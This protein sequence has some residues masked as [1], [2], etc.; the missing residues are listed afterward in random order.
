MTAKLLA[1]L[2]C[3][4]LMRLYAQPPQRF[5]IIITELLPDPAPPIALPNNEFIEL[6]N[7]TTHAINLRGWKLSDGIATA[8]I[9]ANI[10]LQPDSFVIICANAAVPLYTALGNTI[11]ITN[12][13]SLN[14]DADVIT[15]YAP[16]GNAIHTVAYTDL[17]YDNAIKAGGG[18][19]LEMI[20]TRNP[21]TGA[22]NWKAATDDRGGTPGRENSIRADNPDEM[23]P[24]LVGA[25]TID[26]L[27]IV[28]VFDESLDSVSGAIA[29]HYSF[30]HAMGSPVSATP[31]A[32]LFNEVV[33]K[34]PT[35]INKNEVYQLT[36][37]Q[38]ADCSGNTIGMMNNAKAGLPVP[39]DTYDVIINE[40]LFNPP[41][42]GTDYVELYNRSNKTIDLKQ[43]HIANRS[44]A[45][46]LSG[47]Q[48]V[49][50][51]SRLFFPGEYMVLTEDARWLQQQYLIREPAVVIQLPS[52]PSMP[53]DKGTVVITNAQGTIVDEIQYD[54][55]W[56]FALISNED[57]VALERI[58]YSKPTQD[59][60]NWMSAAATAGFG[61]PGY[62]NSQFRA[63]L[64]L[65]GMVTITPSLFSPDND[66]VDDFVN[67][68]CQMTEPGYVANI[69]IFDAAGIPVRHLARSATLGVQGTFRWDG[70]DNNR[71]RLPIGIYVIFTE[72]FNSQGKIKKFRNSVTL[73][74]RF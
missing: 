55:K 63:D 33:L 7:T 25:F 74:R 66:A 39:A 53:D 30:S 44:A 29:N 20:D 11:G 47:I 51:T 27:T 13:P 10:M 38:V 69:T 18:W 15:L 45:G 60:H 26:S 16:E 59:S 22:G 14:N 46:A 41:S 70:L 43:L 48:Q 21:C 72:L 5:D 54:H 40:L 67:I 50:A 19:T 9:N 23:P 71:R 24:A 12:F 34:L 2:L 73:A 61:T 31:Q 65:K 58:D 32:P 49:S 8:T 4:S 36:V 35:A 37:K 42:G 57:G 64:Q 28:A 56:H 68:Q 6:K 17:W 52:L 62:R 3:M 1:L